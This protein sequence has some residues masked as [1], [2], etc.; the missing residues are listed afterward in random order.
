MSYNKKLK[1]YVSAVTQRIT[2]L[3]VGLVVAGHELISVFEV[4]LPH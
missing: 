1:D 2:I 4:V 3:L